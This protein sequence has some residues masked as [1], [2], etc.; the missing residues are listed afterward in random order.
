[1]GE[2]MTDDAMAASA[3]T[4]AELALLC[5]SCGLCCDGSLFGIGDLDPDEVEPARRLRLRV[6]PNARGFE[7]PCA[8][9]SSSGAEHRCSIYEARP[10]ACR[11]FA[12]RLHDR[13]RREGGAIEARLA[14]VR[15]VRDLVHRLEAS[16]W[17]AGD[18]S[19][20]DGSGPLS[21]DREAAMEAYR[22]L[23][24]SLEEDFARA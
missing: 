18:F 12:C 11:R 9:L 23:I 22:E 5:R 14:V 21:R 2:A 10:R 3:R 16:G 24:R 1:M 7:Q 8:A 6:L 4:D 15:R 17:T 13:H 19:E 20:S